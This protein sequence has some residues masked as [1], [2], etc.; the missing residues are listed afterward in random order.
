MSSYSRDDPLYVLW[1]AAVDA[2]TSD[3]LRNPDGS[4]KEAHYDLYQAEAIERARRALTNQPTAVECEDC[5]ALIRPERVKAHEHW[6]ERMWPR[7]EC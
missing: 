2:A 6:H 5:H 7:V 4:R 1:C 3:D